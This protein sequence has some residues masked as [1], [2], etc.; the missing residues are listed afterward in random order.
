MGT[1]AV[2]NHN[3]MDVLTV[4]RACRSARA[5]VCLTKPARTE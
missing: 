2:V 3:H 1:C 5:V 4:A